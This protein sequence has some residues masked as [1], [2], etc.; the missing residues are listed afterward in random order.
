MTKDATDLASVL[1]DALQALDGL[2]A[3]TAKE[4]ARAIL[5]KAAELGH[6]GADYYL[7]RFTNLARAQIAAR[8]RAEFNGRNLQ[9]MMRRYGK[10]KTTIYRM[11][12]GG[13]AN[14]A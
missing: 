4:R 14:G 7:P 12:K 5:I 6:G 8:V 3:E 10:S 1:A 13:K 11:L 2:D 9:E